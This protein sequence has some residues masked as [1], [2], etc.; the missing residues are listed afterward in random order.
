[1]GPPL[2]NGPSGRGGGGG[3]GAPPAAPHVQAA[4][5][6]GLRG[7]LVLTG[8]HGAAE[9]EAAARRRGGTRPDAIAPSL[10]E[11]VAALD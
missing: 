9:V 7:V 2:A 4:K 1:M 5:R 11:V 8:K 3:G 6:V 10:A